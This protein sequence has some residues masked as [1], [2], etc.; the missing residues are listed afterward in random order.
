VINVSFLEKNFNAGDE[1]TFEVLQSMGMV[2]NSTA[3]V[4]ILGDGELSKAL[5]VVAHKFSTGARQKIEAAGG[6][7]R[8]IGA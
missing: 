1:V 7:C 5:K 3:G 8:E 4:K 6:S 2:R